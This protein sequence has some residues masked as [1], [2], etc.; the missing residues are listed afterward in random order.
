MHYTR[1]RKYS[2]RPTPAARMRLIARAICSMISTRSSESR[3]AEGAVLDRYGAN[4][5][6]VRG[7]ASD[8]LYRILIR[9]KMLASHN[10]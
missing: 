9:V 6:V 7:A 4:F 10:S 1:V 2:R 5:G 3:D 8:P